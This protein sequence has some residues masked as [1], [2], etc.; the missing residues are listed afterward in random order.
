MDRGLLAT[1]RTASLIRAAD[2][3]HDRDADLLRTHYTEQHS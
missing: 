2:V 1:S 3:R